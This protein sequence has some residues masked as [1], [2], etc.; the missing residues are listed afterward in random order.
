[1]IKTRT[2]LMALRLELSYGKV[3]M[4][5]EKKIVVFGSPWTE[6]NALQEH[7]GH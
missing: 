3:V 2:I 6:G 1:M 5:N 7:A 4:F